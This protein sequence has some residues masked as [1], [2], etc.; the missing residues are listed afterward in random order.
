MEINNYGDQEI[1][2]GRNFSIKVEVALT[3]EVSLGQIYTTR[4]DFKIST[5][6]VKMSYNG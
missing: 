3:L 1:L 4:V 5:L 2:L 6:D